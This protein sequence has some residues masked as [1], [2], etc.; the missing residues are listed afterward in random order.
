MKFKSMYVLLAAAFASLSLSAQAFEAITV[1]DIRVEGLQRTDPGTV[2]NYLN[3]KV[4]DRFD[5]VQASEA[6]RA[7][8]STGF[9]DDIRIEVDKNIIEKIAAPLM[10]IIRKALDHG[11][12]KEDERVEKIRPGQTGWSDD[13]RTRQKQGNHPGG[14]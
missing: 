10:H 7:L 2:F 1:Q 4:G 11:I 14:L 5:E 9:F 8:F 12:A 13:S 6:I 3:V